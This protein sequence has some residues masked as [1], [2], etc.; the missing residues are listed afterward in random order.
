MNAKY[1]G[2]ADKFAVSTSTICAL[3]CIG[4]PFMISVFPAVGT[5]FFSDEAFHILLL[6]AVIPLSAF[7]L[8]LGCKRH[9]EYSVLRTGIFGVAL[10]VFAALAGHDL[11]GETGERVITLIGAGVIAWAHIRNYRLCRSSDCHHEPVSAQ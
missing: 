5:S 9:K 2:L 7:G 10:L 8:V 3:H 4:L 11:V 6:W 1:I